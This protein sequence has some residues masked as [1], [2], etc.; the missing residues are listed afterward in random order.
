MSRVALGLLTAGFFL[1]FLAVPGRAQAT[2]IQFTATDVPDALGSGGDF[3][4]YSYVVSDF[5]L[6]M[7]V[8]FSVFFDPS[9]YRNLDGPLHLHTNSEPG[10]DAGPDL[11][12][13]RWAA[14]G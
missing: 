8:G 3:W 13:Q 11:Y 7:H 1:M 14:H 5:T 6:P 12:G 10:G 2:T 4:Q 9:L